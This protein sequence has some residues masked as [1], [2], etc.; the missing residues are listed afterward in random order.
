[1][2]KGINGSN[3]VS[4][5][6]GQMNLPYI[7]GSAL[8]AGQMRFNPGTQNFEVYDGITW[9]SITPS[10]ANVDLPDWVKATLDWAHQH[11]MDQQKLDYLC[12]KYP[13]L[14]KARDNFELFKKFVLAQE[15][16]DNGHPVANSGVSAAP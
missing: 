8:S 13:G 1:M 9:K 6:G 14:E 12:E 5:S 16:A 4:V 11:M 2:I 3:Y 15:Q 7:N 10:Y